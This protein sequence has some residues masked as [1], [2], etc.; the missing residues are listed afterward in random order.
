MIVR[1]YEVKAQKICSQVRIVLVTDL[2][3]CYYGEGQEKLVS[4]IYGQAPDIILLG[5]DIF[6][7]RI[8]DTNTERFLAGIAGQ[9][10]IYYVTGNHEYRSGPEKFAIKMSILKKYGVTVLS[11][12]CEVIEINGVKLNLCGADDP[13]SYMV[14][15]D[16]RKDPKGYKKAKLEKLN[17]FDRQLD[18]LKAQAREGYFTILLTH[19]P[20]LF[21]HYVA[22]GF[23]LV[24]CGHAHGGQWRIPGVLNGLLAPN[25]G[26]FPPYAGGRYERGN[27][28]IIVSRGLAKETTFVPRI[29]NPPELVVVTIT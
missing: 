11:G 27:T 2:H 18:A 14:R 15:F 3:S 19:R 28:T 25:Q 13:A 5:G 6:D 10:P 16:R 29:F 24:L 21:E 22:R 26:L 7:D 8:A 9:Y 4:A 17:T 20:E 23:D 1:S 12:V